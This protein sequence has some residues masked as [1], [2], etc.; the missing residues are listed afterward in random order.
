MLLP[1]LTLTGPGHEHANSLR[2][3]LTGPG[4]KHANSLRL[5]LTGPGHEHAN[6]LRLMLTGPG[7]EHANIILQHEAK[8]LQVFHVRAGLSWCLQLEFALAETC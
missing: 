5:T 8:M 7:H 4:H 6:S 1:R 3:M 2:L